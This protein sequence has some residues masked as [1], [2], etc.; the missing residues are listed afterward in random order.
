[1]E[2]TPK[3]KRISTRRLLFILL[4][5]PIFLPGMVLAFTLAGVFFIIGWFLVSSLFFT[6]AF[7]ALLGISNFLSAYIN[8]HNGAGAVLIMIGN[9]FIVLGFVA[10]LFLMAL[11]FAKGF[12]LTSSAVFSVLATLP[13][14]SIREIQYKLSALYEKRR[15]Q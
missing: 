1:M 13:A 5:W 7:A 11:E 8:R 12:M 15:P 14:F 3:D 2:E 4:A 9:G 10:P 6:S